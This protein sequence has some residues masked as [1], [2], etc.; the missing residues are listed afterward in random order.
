[1]FAWLQPRPKE[2]HAMGNVSWLRA[3]VLGANDGILSVSGLLI[4]VSSAE[5][6]QRNIALTGVSGLIAGA[7]SMAAGEYV[8]VSSQADLETADL[9][10][11][12]QEM[13]QHWDEEVIELTNVYIKRG[14]DRELARTVA[15]KLMEHDALEAHARDELGINMYSIAKPLQASLSSAGAFS[16][17]AILPLITALLSPI[18]H[19]T[20]I[21]TFSTLF[22]LAFLGIVGAQIG[23]A[24][25]MRA[26]FRVTVLGVIAMAVTSLV[27]KFFET[28]T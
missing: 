3:A 11:E 18:E 15:T 17:G 5:V 20:F 10:L 14:L 27:G 21:L 16:T 9:D 7:L 25:R 13:E 2:K 26:I 24:N 19:V 28:P 22:F 1:M 8:S 12:R 23:G 4:G 6:S